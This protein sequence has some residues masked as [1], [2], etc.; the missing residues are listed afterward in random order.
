METPT[1]QRFTESAECVK[2]GLA[3]VLLLNPDSALH[4]S[5]TH[6]EP[7]PPVLFGMGAV[8][9]IQTRYCPGGQ[10]PEVEQPADPVLA[11]F[12]MLPQLANKQLPT[13]RPKL[14]ICAGIGEEH[15]HKTCPR[16]GFE[17]LTGTKP[18]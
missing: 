12:S 5:L 8:S 11:L 10:E 1:I 6:H 14:N 4:R 13:L 7:V 9:V 16:C 3:D 17:W 15:L 2:C 18:A